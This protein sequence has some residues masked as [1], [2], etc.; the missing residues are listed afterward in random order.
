MSGR[1]I[2][3]AG[4]TV[5]G[6]VSETEFERDAR[7]SVAIIG[8]YQCDLTENQLARLPTAEDGVTTMDPICAAECAFALRARPSGLHRRPGGSPKLKA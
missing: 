5:H 8:D 3:C 6:E 7:S 2:S 4:R 1:I